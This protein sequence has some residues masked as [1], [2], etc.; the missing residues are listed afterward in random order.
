RVRFPPSI[1]FIN[2]R[3]GGFF[4]D[5]SVYRHVSLSSNIQ[6]ITGVTLRGITPTRKNELPLM[7]LSD[8]TV[9]NTKPDTKPIKLYD[10]RGLYLMVTPA[11]GKW[12]RFRFKFDGKE[13]V[14]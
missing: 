3:N 8:I 12:W 13:K 11:G 6:K 2:P 14:A 9:R 7:S 1:K 4:I 5:F 10:G